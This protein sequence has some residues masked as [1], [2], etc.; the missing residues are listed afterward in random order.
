MAHEPRV[1]SSTAS[2]RVPAPD[3]ERTPGSR[4][5]LWRRLIFT[6]LAVAA[7]VVLVV[8][9]R[10]LL[11]S[12]LDN[13]THA[14]F[15]WLL[16]ALAAEAVSLTA[17]GLSRQTLL[18]ANGNRVRLHSV[19][20]VTY[21][22]HALSQSVPLAGTELGI[23]YSY[24][25][26]RRRGL[27]A[28]TTGWSLAV[29]W[30]C[31]TSSLALLL[32]LG[33]VGSGATAASAAGFAGAALYLL[34]GAAVVLAIRFGRVRVA[35]QRVLAF[36]AGLSRRMFGKPGNGGDGL[37]AFLDEVS[38]TRL[39]AA[40]YARAFA[41]AFANWALDCAA[42][43]LA[44][45]AMGEPVPWG[46]LLLVYGAGAVV[47][48]TGLTPGGL[49]LVEATLTAALVAASRMHQPDAFAAV[50]AFRAVSFWLPLL[51]G[52]IT[53]AILSHRQPSAP[54]PGTKRAQ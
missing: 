25:E 44:I 14:N 16:L 10:G 2:A 37:E 31:S 21:A 49:G 22:S 43:A 36:L 11:A 15:G 38:R 19:M 20:A 34:P 53:L 54:S 12:S 27:D 9:E 8:L 35:L 32:L 48:S 46:N 4:T 29:S 18:R 28:A 41:A 42:L 17:F 52:W 30:I 47:V 1:G 33:A 23:V 7:V 50:L 26:F 51:S 3:P 40:G 6:V 39:P 13:L 45:R 24:R 5:G